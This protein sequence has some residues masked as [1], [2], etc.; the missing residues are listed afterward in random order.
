MWKKT[1]GLGLL[2]V[3]LS[4]ILQGCY[5]HRRAYG[6]RD[7]FAPA[8]VKVRVRHG[9]G[10]GRGYYSHRPYYRHHDDDRYDRRHFKKFKRHHKEDWRRRHD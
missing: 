7:G 5:S 9:H 2:L 10:F 4:L 8:Y 1:L 3:V 6:Y